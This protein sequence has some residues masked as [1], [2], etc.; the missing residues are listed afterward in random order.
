MK[1]R[2][3]VIDDEEAIRG[4]LSTILSESGYDVVEAVDGEDGLS[5]AREMRPDLITLDVM[6]PK[7]T[8]VFVLGELRRDGEL[9][10]VPVIMLTSVKSFIEQSYKELD[11]VDAIK[12]METLLDEPASKMQKFFLRFKSFRK[13]L[14]IDREAMIEQFRKGELTL[15]GMPSLPDIFL[16]KPVE[17]EEFAHA[18]NKLIGQPSE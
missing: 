2:V 8:G 3:L 11:N 18:V 1:R 12:Q 5:K 13:M 9:A 7:K 10:N 4:Y 17:P 14:L 16:D 6:M 15:G